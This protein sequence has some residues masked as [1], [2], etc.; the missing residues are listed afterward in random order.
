MKGVRG[1]VEHR[2]VGETN[3]DYQVGKALRWN[4]ETS[5]EEKLLNYGILNYYR[6]VI[7]VMLKVG[8]EGRLTRQQ[9]KQDLVFT[10]SYVDDVVEVSKKQSVE[11][12]AEENR[13]EEMIQALRKLTLPGKDSRVTEQRSPEKDV[14][15]KQEIG[16]VSPEAELTNEERILDVEDNGKLTI[17]TEKCTQE[18]EHSEAS[19]AAPNQDK[20]IQQ[21]NT[22]ESLFKM[23]MEFVYSERIQEGMYGRLVNTNQ[24]RCECG[25]GRVSF[26][27]W[28]P[29]SLYEAETLFDNC[30]NQENTHRRYLA[31]SW[32]AFVARIAATKPWKQQIKQE[33]YIQ[34]E[35][36]IR[37][38]C[39]IRLDEEVPVKRR[40][41]KADCQGIC[42]PTLRKQ[43]YACLCDCGHHREECPVHQKNL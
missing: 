33:I 19:T 43:K 41:R 14:D 36:E 39:D 8:L 9:E 13:L 17:A 4:E 2:P 12:E 15:R 5:R 26:P 30:L 42:E 40:R 11:E 28:P 29:T 10:R 38:A 16:E 23:W 22:K 27:H 21:T 37:E 25:K 35:R 1:L 24:G 34:K 3:W 6:P 20:D 32:W 31:R 7:Q 18:S